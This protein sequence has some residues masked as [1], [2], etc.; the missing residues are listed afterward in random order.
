MIMRALTG[1]KPPRLAGIKSLKKPAD[2]RAS[3]AK[4]RITVAP[5]PHVFPPNRADLNLRAPNVAEFYELVGRSSA[6]CPRLNE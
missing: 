6:L 1:F 2:S 5:P 3:R 4:S